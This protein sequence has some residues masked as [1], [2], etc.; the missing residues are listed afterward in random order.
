MPD[1]TLQKGGPALREAAAAP[2]ERG[3]LLTCSGLWAPELPLP[4]GLV[5]PGSSIKKH[6]DPLMQKAAMYWPCPR[7]TLPSE[8]LL[9]NTQK[10]MVAKGESGM[11]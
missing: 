5:H 1:F 4:W 10:E 3:V 11:L 2:R 8:A 7:F 9:P 6:Q